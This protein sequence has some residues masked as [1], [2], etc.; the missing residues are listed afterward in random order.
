MSCLSAE[1]L[2]ALVE[3]RIESADREAI[4]AHVEGCDACQQRL[5]Q[6]Q[7]RSSQAGA[8]PSNGD[9]AELRE[10]DLV[11]LERLRGLGRP[12]L[13]SGVPGEPDGPTGA[14]P[15][16]S[17]RGFEILREIGRGGMGVV[18]EA[19]DVALGRR[20]ALKVL[21]AQWAAHP[22]AIGRFR[23]EARAAGRLHHTNIVPVFGVG[24]DQGK[25]YYAMQYVDGEGLDRIWKRLRGEGN[26]NAPQPGSSS[27]AGPTSGS[28]K[29]DAP[30]AELLP[31]HSS[32]ANGSYYDLVA[33][34]GQ[35]VAEALAFAH[36]HRIIHRDIKHSNLLVDREG[37]V[38]V[39]DFGL[40]S[41]F[42][43][44]DA[45]TETGDVMGTIRY[46][47]PERFQGVAD[48]RG[49]VYALGVT[50]YELLTL[51]HLFPVVERGQLIDR[52]QHSEPVAPRKLDR[53]IPRDLNTIVLKAIAKEPGRRYQTAADL[54]EDLRRF[55]AGMPLKGKPTGAIEHGWLW[56]RRNPWLATAAGTVLTAIVT[57]I[58]L[59]TVFNS[60]LVDLNVKLANSSSQSNQRLIALNFEQGY[61]A[62]E[63][64]ESGPGLLRIAESHRLAVAAGDAGWMHTSETNLA[65]WHPRFPCVKGVFS[66]A[67]GITC[68]ALSPDGK[69]VVTGSR[70]KTA[71]LWDVESGRPI[72]QPMSHDGV[73]TV[74]L[75]SPD[76][77]SV[78]TGSE[79]KTARLWDSGTGKPALSALEHPAPVLAAAFSPDG[80]LLVTGCGKGGWDP[81]SY[82]GTWSTPVPGE[83]SGGGMGR[84]P[85]GYYGD[86]I[87]WDTKSGEAVWR[88]LEPDHQKALNLAPVRWVAFDPTGKTLLLD[89]AYDVREYDIQT[90]QLL[91]RKGLI[92][93]RAVAPK[94][95]R[96]IGP[97]PLPRLKATFSM[98]E[99]TTIYL[100]R[101][102]TFG[103]WQNES[104]SASPEPRNDEAA[105][106]SSLHKGVV[107]ALTRS[108]DGKTLVTGGTDKVVRFWDS[109]SCKPVGTPLVHQ[110]T[111][112]AL[113]FSPDGKALLAGCDDGIARLW[114]LT[115]QAAAQQPLFEWHHV[116][117]WALSRDG[118]RMPVVT[119]DGS[120][121]LFDDGTF[122][123][124]SEVRHQADPNPGGSAGWWEV[125]FV[126]V[127]ISPD[128]KTVYGVRRSVKEPGGR[129][130]TYVSGRQQLHPG[131]DVDP[132][133]G[134]FGVELWDSGRGRLVERFELNIEDVG[135]ITLSPDGRTVVTGGEGGRTQAWDTASWN[136]IGPEKLVH[137]DVH[138]VSFSPDG[139]QIVVL[140]RRGKSLAFAITDYGPTTFDSPEGT[141]CAAYCPDSRGVLVGSRD[142]TLSVFNVAT[143][144]QATM[145]VV[146]QV[147]VRSLAYAVDG[148]S[149]IIGTEDGMVQRW[150]SV[151]WRP[152][153]RP[154]AHPRA[155]VA[156]KTSGDS[157]RFLSVAAD[158]KLRLWE[159][160]RLPVAPSQ[161]GT[162]A[163]VLTG[164]EIGSQGSI[165]A[166]ENEAW[167]DR[168]DRL[169]RASPAPEASQ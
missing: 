19:I 48:E 104:A 95:V 146:L 92:P 78:L 71:K 124:I 37:N 59:L 114:D 38:W 55:Q 34:L 128:G 96:L 153:G 81:N 36:A 39:A 156:L 61:A 162:W 10:S 35:Q 109:V 101:D 134:Q 3:G 107:T 45:L 93:L 147:P 28:E 52:I 67:R 115:S 8:H 30:S 25:L 102:N 33:R 29:P 65:E 99:N 6:L 32:G 2:F 14:A 44:E 155:I 4:D 86:A 89:N 160:P 164:T 50:L 136:P 72:G 122:K 133:L 51:K 165:M 43:G 150:D 137:R 111:V 141:T 106:S 26:D 123:P 41:A 27:P 16:P 130:R 161:I 58:V 91:G 84:F 142:G 77:K 24:E 57:V 31:F 85:D 135:S 9:D 126:A 94:G 138:H 158:G 112:T 23:R 47:A 20:V 154:F 53:R 46:M 163:E 79:D 140:G 75:F 113:G 97:D 131:D 60:K 127:E 88:P 152:I 7:S 121:Y 167:L 116:R 83:S 108:S 1:E 74:A 103:F 90:K 157:R 168:R 151:T 62:L 145:P 125:P 17:I 66:H 132:R 73:V 49:D 148:R 118:K 21:P 80:R 40:A 64:G 117:A 42:E 22:L 98:V 18:Y 15:L 5:E 110:G 56:C 82:R 143:G 68:A 87:L 105:V 129:L 12:G 159:F 149:I 169:Q 139:R 54:A 120:L 13:A 69:R 63:R 11:F 119:G 100:P 144:T 166:L 70:D 76:G